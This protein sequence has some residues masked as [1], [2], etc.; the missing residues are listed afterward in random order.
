MLSPSVK[1][2]CENLTAGVSFKLLNLISHINKNK[3]SYTLNYLIVKQF[4]K[5]IS[6]RKMRPRMTLNG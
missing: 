2:V 1:G 3:V 4:K 5:I 6:F